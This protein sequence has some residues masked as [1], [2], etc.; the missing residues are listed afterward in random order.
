MNEW[1][2]G[3]STGIMVAGI[4]ILLNAILDRIYSK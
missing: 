3:Y 4:I 2:L 1:I